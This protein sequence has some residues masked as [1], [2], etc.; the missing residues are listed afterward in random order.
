MDRVSGYDSI[1]DL[2]GARLG[3]GVGEGLPCWSHMVGSSGLGVANRR[4]RLFAV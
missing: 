2:L 1:V 4:S 3:A